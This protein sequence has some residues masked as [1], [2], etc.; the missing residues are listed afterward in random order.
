[1]DEVK[2]KAF[3]GLFQPLGSKGGKK[4]IHRFV[5][6]RESNTKDLDQVKMYKG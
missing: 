4:V 5:K 2:T 1:M 3:D 6:G